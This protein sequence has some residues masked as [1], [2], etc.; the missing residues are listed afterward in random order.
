M[1]I[2]GIFHCIA[3]S[4]IIEPCQ[5]SSSG[6][7]GV[8]GE[9]ARLW[10]VIMEQLWQGATQ[11]L[12]KH[13]IEITFGLVILLLALGGWLIR[14]GGKA[15][16]GVGGGIDENAASKRDLGVALVVGSLFFAASLFVQLSAEASNFRM[17]IAVSKDLTGFDPNDRSL[18]EMTFA[19]KN[20]NRAKFEG[21][22]LR[23][24][25]LSTAYLGEA[26]L[27]NAN[28]RGANLFYAVLL[29]AN[30]INTDLTGA[31]LQGAELS[32]DILEAQLKKA[33]V[34]RE[35]CWQIRLQ[36]SYMWPNEEFAQVIVEDQPIIDK[37]ITSGLDPKDDK[38]LGHVCDSQ[39]LKRGVDNQSSGQPDDPRVYICTDGTLRPRSLEN[40]DSACDGTEASAIAVP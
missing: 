16:P 18:Q 3:C 38:T 14:I 4:E 5:E 12:Q 30:L 24:A 32:T 31:D 6:R 9:A 2:A 19:G 1:V 20:L 13:A 7:G 22:N 21:A 36:E 37:L 28:L 34:H 29:R 10:G 40:R 23:D 33:K 25:D 39:E 27:K 15:A 35:T 11:E 8:G 17:T 26:N